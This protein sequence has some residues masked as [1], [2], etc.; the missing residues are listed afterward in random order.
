[1]QTL[2]SLINL[3]PYE[4]ANYNFMCN[5]LL[6]VLIIAPV[7][8]IMGTMV[9][10]N[11]MAFF[12]DALGHSALTGVAIGVIF[13]LQDPLIA[14]I[15]FAIIFALAVSEV[16]RAG[17]S[18]ADTVISV[19]SSTA[20]AAGIALLSKN[21]DFSKYNSYLIG[22]LLSITPKELFTLLCVFVSITLILVLIFKSLLLISLNRSLAKSRGIKVRLIENIFISII[23]VLVTV[24]VSRTGILII[25]SML[26]LPAAAS[27]NVAKNINSYVIISVLI[28][29]LCGISGL[30]T[31]FYTN[32]S[33]GATIILYM[34]ALF[35]ASLVFTIFTKRSG[36]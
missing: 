27:R 8:G 2:Y 34:A 6:A 25:N 29:C 12:S 36:K 9:V 18:S 31:S 10:S 14:A 19:F 17:T 23:A 13:G 33:A 15:G 26:I 11:Q 1:M 4:W 32:T 22:D 28:S 7:F 16:K 35:F 3:L 24:S 5:A 20:L 30:I 21:G